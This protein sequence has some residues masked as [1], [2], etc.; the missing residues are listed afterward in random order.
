LTVLALVACWPSLM[1]SASASVL[2]RPLPL[3]RF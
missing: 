2:M 3:P 1:L